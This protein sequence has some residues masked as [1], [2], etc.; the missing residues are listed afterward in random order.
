MRKIFL[1]LITVSLSFPS[2]AQSTRR[3]RQEVKRNRINEMVKQEEEGVITYRKSFLFGAKLTT[4]GY[5]IFFELGRASSVKKAML[6]QLEIG[7][8]K[9]TKEDKQSSI[10]SN[11][12]PFIFGKENFFYPVKLG[13]QQQMLLGNKSN[14]NGVAVT[15]NYGGGLSLA[16]LRPY[17][18]QAA[19]GN[20]IEYVK[21]SSSDSLLFLNPGAIYGGPSISKGWN[22]MTVTPGVYAKAAVRFD[23]GSYNEMISAIEVGV[24]GEYYSKKIPQMVYAKEKQFF[25]GGYVAILFGKR[26]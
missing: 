20:N 26:K 13:V 10:Y 4:D 16:L 25:F 15:A 3:T 7:E 2:F 21:Y 23:Y 5:G 6:Y 14:K 9:H 11:S 24:T 19:K 12:V 18:V 8:R 22:E 1:V 17:Y